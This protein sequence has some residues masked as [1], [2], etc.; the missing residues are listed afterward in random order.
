MAK[1]I[2]KQTQR[3]FR[4]KVQEAR[5]EHDRLLTRVFEGEMIRDKYKR[6]WAQIQGER[7]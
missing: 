1:P 4:A 2:A 5:T 6:R 7:T 3:Q